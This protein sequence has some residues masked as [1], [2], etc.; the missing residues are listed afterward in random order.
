MRRGHRLTYFGEP[1]WDGAP[2]PAWGAAVDDVL[3]RLVI[4]LGSRGVPVI[5]RLPTARVVASPETTRAVEVIRGVF[6]AHTIEDT[7]GGCRLTL[8]ADEVD[9]LDFAGD[10]YWASGSGRASEAGGMAEAALRIWVADPVLPPGFA[11]MDELLR[12]LRADATSL[13]RRVRQYYSE[14]GETTRP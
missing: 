8:H 5:D 2:L 6:G 3:F 7:D 12:S 4:A 13:V 11:D 14:V 9:I 10:A 1:T